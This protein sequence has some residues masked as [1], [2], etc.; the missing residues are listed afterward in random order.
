MAVLH[1]RWATLFM[2]PIVRR[3]CCFISSHFYSTCIGLQ[4]CCKRS[5][6]YTKQLL[7]RSSSG[8][9]SRHRVNTSTLSN[10]TD[11]YRSNESN[12]YTAICLLCSEI[13]QVPICVGV[14]V[15]EKRRAIERAR[16]K[17]IKHILKT[18]KRVWNLLQIPT[19]YAW[20]S[21][22]SLSI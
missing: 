18:L 19:R 10:A 5:D 13:G 1:S 2:P 20:R 7:Y 17:K 11:P 16:R 21:K 3:F 8:Y 4:G 9:S 22:D 15:C 6:M 14:R 12:T